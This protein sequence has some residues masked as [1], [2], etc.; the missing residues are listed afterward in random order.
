L[1]SIRFRKRS[2]SSSILRV[3]SSYAACS[4][5]TL[6]ILFAVVLD[7]LLWN[8]G[9]FSADIREDGDHDLDRLVVDSPNGGSMAA[10]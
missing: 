9:D 10:G 2:R 6:F 4:A 8:P 7:D 3:G 5:E 1:A